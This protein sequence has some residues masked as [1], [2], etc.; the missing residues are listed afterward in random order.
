L[1]WGTSTDVPI[2]ADFDGDR[3]ADRTFYR[4]ANGTWNV[5]RS[6]SGFTTAFG[7]QWGAPG[8]VPL[9]GDLDGDGR[10]DL[11]VWRPATGTFFW[12]TS[13]TGYA[14]ANA[15]S[16]QWGNQSLGDIPMLADVDGDR[17]ADLVVWRTSTGTWYW[18]TSLTGYSYTASGIRQWGNQTQGDVPLIGDVDGDGRADLIVWRRPS[19]MWFWL[20]SSTGYDPARQGLKQ[21]GASG[22]VPLLIDADGD[23]VMDIAVWRPSN[24]SWYWLT[25]AA[26]F[27]YAAATSLS[28]GNAGLGDV[29]VVK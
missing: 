15:Q 4:P 18:L 9:A 29:P 24:G 16:K 27:S 12:L 21:W 23:R 14:T 3:V 13:S 19:G 25:W 8:D 28:W 5:L 1:P 10:A 17:R 22:D 11:V 20:M 6:S 7:I 2:A 26:S